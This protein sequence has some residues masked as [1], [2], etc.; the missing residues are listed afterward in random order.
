MAGNVARNFVQSLQSGDDHANN[1]NPEG[2]FCEVDDDR[3]LDTGTAQAIQ[4]PGHVA[5]ETVAVPIRGFLEAARSGTCSRAAQAVEGLRVAMI[6]VAVASGVIS[7][8]CDLGQPALCGLGQRPQQGDG[9][10]RVCA[11][12]ERGWDIAGWFL[13]GLEDH[14]P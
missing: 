6:A 11:A 12:S 4:L 9:S 14:T 7:G 1:R 13:L 3:A 10:S 5:F 2:V 8:A